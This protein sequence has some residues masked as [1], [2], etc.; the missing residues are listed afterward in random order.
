MKKSAFFVFIICFSYSAKAQSGYFMDDNSEYAVIKDTDGFVNIRKAP[1]NNAPIIGKIKKYEVFMCD[2]TQ[3]NWWKVLYTRYDNHSKSIWLEGYIYKN[4]VSL[5]S[6]WKTINKKDSTSIIVKEASFEPNKHSLSFSTDN[7]DKKASNDLIKIDGKVFWGTDG[8]IPKEVISHVEVTIKGTKVILPKNAFDD[9]YEPSLG[10]ISIC[11][12]PENT[13]Y[14]KM[15][16]NSD[17]AGAY[18]I[19]WVIK[20]NKYYGRYIDDSNE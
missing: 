4:R 9:L 8:E 19:V 17:G 2:R 6:H 18:T 11:H 10:N 7:S 12:G 14:I 20:D 13:L 1:N 3:T 15:D 16:D 5:L